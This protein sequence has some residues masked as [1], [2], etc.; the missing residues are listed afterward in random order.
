MKVKFLPMGVEVEVDPNKSILQLATENH[1]EIRS[2]CKGVPS[3]AECRVKVVEGGSNIQPPNKAELGLIGTSYYL[4][5]RRLACQSHCYGDVVVDVTEHL[6][7]NTQ[8]KKIRGFKMDKT[9]ESRA[10]L[11][12][13]ILS[14]PKDVE[15]ESSATASGTPATSKGSG[16]QRQSHNQNHNK[17]QGK[18]Q[19]R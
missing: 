15:P 13:M 9:H 17:P 3:C 10:V 19:R 6:D 2:I 7:P 14:T 16:A 11:D 8:T 4:D 12:T 5:S 1:I 18:P